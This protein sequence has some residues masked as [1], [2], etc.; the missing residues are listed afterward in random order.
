MNYITHFPGE[1]IIKISQKFS[2][3]DLLNCLHFAYS[4]SRGV[5]RLERSEQSKSIQLLHTVHR[6]NYKICTHHSSH[7]HLQRWKNKSEYNSKCFTTL[8]KLHWICFLPA[9]RI[10]E[11]GHL[12][13][14]ESYWRWRALA[15]YGV[16]FMLTWDFLLSL[17]ANK[18]LPWASSLHT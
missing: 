10:F 13:P 17:H 14:G 5:Q 9:L 8:K 16:R 2:Q 7:C 18:G 12:T 1:Y 4:N 3:L 6:R 15:F 11:K